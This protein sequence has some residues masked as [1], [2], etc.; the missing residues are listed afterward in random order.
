MTFLKT[1]FGKS[2]TAAGFGNWFRDQCVAAGVEFRAHGLRKAIC[3]R[4]VRMGMTPHQIAAITG[5]TDLR[6]I[7]L[8]AAEFDR[9]VAAKQSM[10]AL[11]RRKTDEA[12]S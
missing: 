12:K 9:E 6:E 3:I 7:E 1:S 11:E 8:Y 5:H 10:A 4:L 2:Y